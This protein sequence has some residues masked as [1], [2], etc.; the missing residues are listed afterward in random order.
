MTV[1]RKKVKSIRSEVLG[2]SLV[3]SLIIV[4]VFGLFLSN[5]LYREGISRAY[6]IIKQRNYAVNFFIDSHFSE[7]NHIIEILSADEDV[8]NAPWRDAAARERVLQLYKTYT[9]AN[10]NITYLYSGYDNG[11]LLINDY[12]PPKGFNPTVRPWYKAALAAKPGLASGLLYQ[13]IKSREWLFST[14]K[15]M[16]SDDGHEGVVSCDLSIEMIADMLKLHGEVYKSAYSYVVNSD[17]KII[18]HQNASYLRRDLSDIVG[19]SVALNAAE[20]RFAYK[21]GNTD[22]IAFYSR[23]NETAWIVVTVV[24]KAEIFDAI[25]W[26]ILYGLLITGL[27]AVLLGIVQS[28]FLGRRFSRPLIELRKRVEAI[29][30]GKHDAVSGYDY[31]NNEIGMIAREVGQLASDELYLKSQELKDANARLE[32]KND[33]LKRLSE[34][35][36]LTGL[37]NRHKIAAE[38]QMQQ[39]MAVRYGSRFSLI[40]LDIDRFKNINDTYGHPVGDTVLREMS[41]LFKE[42]VRKTDIVGRWGGEEFLII[43]PE[44]DLKGAYELGEKLRTAVEAHR[45]KTAGSVTISVGVCEYAGQ[46]VETLLKCVDKNLYKAKKQGRN[47]IVA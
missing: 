19:A 20:G 31:P 21:I 40:M 45:F 2:S 13:E 4:V 47:S 22:K 1:N 39:A 41:L 34:T 9:K 23:C 16:V 7:I 27:V 14:S 6:A 17:G 36:Q 30:L 29:V 42:N 38:L 37:Y 44:T 28:V 26:R 46:T 18:I 8:R 33:E 32:R 24:D 3:F 35:D 15:A 43:C 5:L 25:G 10:K 11:E 12:I